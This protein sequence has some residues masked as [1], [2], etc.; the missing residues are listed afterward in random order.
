MR[1]QP[2][3]R[4]APDDPTYPPLGVIATSLLF[5]A[6]S[7]TTLVSG[8]VQNDLV[9]GESEPTGA[10]MLVS[11]DVIYQYER[12]IA[13]LQRELLHYRRM[14][15]RLF[16]AGLRSEEYEPDPI[17]P[18]DTASTRLINSVIDARIPSEAIFL[19]FQEGEL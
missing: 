2:R 9:I 8:A 7:G 18:L 12:R 13:E 1:S 16:V 5:D 17:L 4:L 15:A 6:S 19:D 14:V 3:L 11:P 10:Y